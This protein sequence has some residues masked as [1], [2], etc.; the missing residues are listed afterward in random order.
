M[1]VV[2]VLEHEQI[3]EIAASA[4]I[5]EPE[6]LPLN[7]EDS[8]PI[9]LG[10]MVGSP[11]PYLKT[12]R[13]AD[14]GFMEFPQLRYTF[15]NFRQFS[16]TVKVWRGDGPV[17]VLPRAEHMD[18]IDAIT[19]ETLGENPVTMTWEQSLQAN[20]T[21]GIVVLHRGRIVYERYFGALK[22]HGQHAAFSVTK[23]F[24]GLLGAILV[25]EG[26]I[27]E[28]ALVTKYV[29]EL[30]GSAF[31]DATVRQVLDMTTGIKFSEE[32][33]NPEAEIWGHSRA[34]NLLQRP[35]GYAGPDNFYAFMQTV[36]K[37]GG[38]GE[39]FDY[40]T[41]NSDVLGWIIHRTS[42]KKEP[43]AHLLQDRIWSQLGMEQDAYL[44][45]DNLG[46]GFAGGGLNASLRDMARFGEMMR[47]DG[48]LQDCQIVPKAVIDDIRNGGDKEDF[49][50]YGAKT[51]PGWS[52]R[53]M[54]WVS[55][56]EHGAY[57]A[58]GIYG[59]TIYV[60]PTAEMVIARFA[61]FPVAANKQIDP[62]SLPAY[63]A[64][65]KYLVANPG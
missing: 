26:A 45:V 61:S 53:N 37:V 4:A 34:G 21:D 10:W 19:F 63:H 42:D 47:L 51:M 36:K 60:D 59:Q 43:F 7:A 54:W 30:E 3:E 15:S 1:S 65:A 44:T 22:P 20:Y 49:K 56:N 24:T 48:K 5:K 16:A 41:V 29:P 38:H 62:T 31:G 27:D 33:A 17:S 14:S 39:K 25:H 8:D 28:K 23:S 32:Y 57:A 11:P 52:Y 58:K 12:V 9:T 18:P 46:V 40:K 35:H 50:K 64:L 13:F 2:T 55:H 6:A